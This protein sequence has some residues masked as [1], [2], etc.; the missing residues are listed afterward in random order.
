MFTEA[1][2]PGRRCKSCLFTR[3]EMEKNS[4]YGWEPKRQP[5]VFVCTWRRR[6][7]FFFSDFAW[8]MKHG[9]QSLD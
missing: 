4:S 5:Y 8:S 7:F 9:Y 3:M 1:D 2:G 6:V